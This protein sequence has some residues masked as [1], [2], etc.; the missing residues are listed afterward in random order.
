MIVPLTR[1]NA[2]PPPESATPEGLLAVGGDLS[3]ERLVAAYRAG[4]FPWYGPGQPILWWSPD[5]RG[6]IELDRF[7]VGRSLRKALRRSPFEIRVD[8]A[9]EAVIRACAR[10]RELPPEQRWITP[11]MIEAY[12]RLHR[13]GIAHSVEAW[14]DGRLAGGLYGVAVGGLF[15]GESMFHRE[16][17]ASRAALTAL[18]DRLRERGFGLLDCQMLTPVTRAMGAVEIPRRV[19]LERLRRLRDLPCRFEEPGEGIP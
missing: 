11:E 19:Y 17:N 13:A 7:H 5:P 3:V 8:S 18:V 10:T 15:A 4:I 2:F 16:S 6:V 14:R 9:F 12:L 1:E